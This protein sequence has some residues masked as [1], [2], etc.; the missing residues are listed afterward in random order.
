MQQ[1]DPSDTAIVFDWDDTLLAS[2]WLTSE[3]LR[4]DE[5]AHIPE[6]ARSALRE[7]EASVIKLLTHAQQL[8]TVIIVTN[9]ETGWV[10]LSAERFMPGVVPFL[11]G[12]RVLSARSTYEAQFPDAPQ[13]WKVCAF[14]AAIADAFC[15]NS[16]SCVRPGKNILSFGDSIHERDAVHRVVGTMTNT[17]CKSVK[18][19]ERPTMEQLRR[20]IGLVSDCLDYI[21]NFGGN[22]DLMLTI[23]LLYN[24]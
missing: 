6:D 15:C 13:E 19:V 21:A 8:G 18:F 1:L 20:Q 5:P 23:Q 17:H 22:L 2:S 12:V 11:S 3:G 14:E 10:E 9:A 24:Q 4:L 7:L 16:I